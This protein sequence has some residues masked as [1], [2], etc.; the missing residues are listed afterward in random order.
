MPTCFAARL[1]RA[2]AW[3]RAL[4]GLGADDLRWLRDGG[5]ARARDC[6]RAGRTHATATAA[7]RPVDAAP[8]YVAPRDAQA[9][10]SGLRAALAVVLKLV[11]QY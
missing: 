1:R 4:P 7:R 6:D 10:L 8:L 11:V 2:P 5:H 9:G 3:T